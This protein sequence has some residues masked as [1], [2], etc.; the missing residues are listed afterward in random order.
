MLLVHLTKQILF[1]K[2]P[3]PKP[4]SAENRKI[5]THYASQGLPIFVKVFSLCLLDPI[6]LIDS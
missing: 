2:Q 4:W 1:V 3:L 5:V 6:G